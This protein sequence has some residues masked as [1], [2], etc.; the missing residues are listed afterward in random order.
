M[1]PFPPRIRS[2]YRESLIYFFG[3]RELR[4]K[5]WD[6]DPK[7]KRL[8]PAPR[9]WPHTLSRTTVL[10]SE[11]CADVLGF[12]DPFSIKNSNEFTMFLV[13][14]P[15]LPGMNNGIALGKCKWNRLYLRRFG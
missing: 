15:I 1:I 4:L 13:R 11:L 9:V 8:F 10:N 14:H 6:D 5:W 3:L 12:T 2:P 7:H